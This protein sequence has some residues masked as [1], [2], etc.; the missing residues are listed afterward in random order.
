MTVA[1]YFVDSRVGKYNMGLHMYP[2]VKAPKRYQLDKVYYNPATKQ[3]ELYTQAQ[4]NDDNWAFAIKMFSDRLT[5][6]QFEIFGEYKGL[7]LA[8]EN[9]RGKDVEIWLDSSNNDNQWAWGTSIAYRHAMKKGISGT[10]Y[11]FD[12]YKKANK[13]IQRGVLN[14]KGKA[15]QW[16]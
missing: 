2:N 10:A 15:P 8:L 4:Y 13:K 16:T 1:E 6:F 7:V 5:H 12:R 9:K 11:I 14:A 3:F